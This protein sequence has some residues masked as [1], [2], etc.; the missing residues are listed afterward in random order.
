MAASEGMLGK[1]GIATS[2]APTSRL[3][4]TRESLKLV[5]PQK[6]VNGLRG[7]LSH[8]L[9]RT[10]ADLKRVGGALEL[11][12]NSL[13]WSLLLQWIMGGTPTGSPTVTY[14]L[15]DTLVT[16]D[17]TVDRISDKFLYA[18]CAVDRA[19]FRSSR[20]EALSLS[21][22]LVG[23]TETVGATFSGALNIDVTTTPFMFYDAV[24]TVGGTTVTPTDVEV[25]VNN[26]IDRDRYFNSLT[27]TSTVKQDRTVTFACSVPDGDQHALYAAGLAGSNVVLTFTNGGA[28]L[29]VTLNKVT[30]TTESPEIPGRSEI[31][32]PVRGMAYASGSG[33]ATRELSIALNPGP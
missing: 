7:T 21:L 10:R 14:P 24:I 5:Q 31:F 27:L 17:V 11:Q 22:D 18:G 26:F 4:F 13:E 20:G 8:S 33:P 6:D 32:L 9:E 28:V 25:A 1:L 2:G 30:Y 19:V 15:A 12:P 29:T 23:L 3:D 16:R